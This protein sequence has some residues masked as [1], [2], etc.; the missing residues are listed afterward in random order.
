MYQLSYNN[1]SEVLAEN[2]NA[3]TKI[4]ELIL[5]DPTGHSPTL[6]GGTIDRDLNT[7]TYTLS[8]N[9]FNSSSPNTFL[10]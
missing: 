2:E 4:S 7:I 1:K 6:Q 8:N 9:A 10:L 3:T 5:Y